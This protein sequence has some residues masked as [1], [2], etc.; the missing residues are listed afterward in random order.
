MMLTT[1]TSPLPSTPSL[2]QPLVLATTEHMSAT[3]KN[4]R[5]MQE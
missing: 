2:Y 4:K 3:I 1:I 5:E